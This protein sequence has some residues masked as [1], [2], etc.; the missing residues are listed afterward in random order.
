[1]ERF[2]ISIK[3]GVRIAL[4]AIWTNKTRAILTTTCIVI[5]IV[6]VT[7]MN[8]VTDGVDR[9]F[10]DSMDMLGR[11]VVYIEKWPWGL[12]GGDYKWWEYRNRR[13]IELDYI[14]S[15]QERSR[16]ASVVS[17]AAYASSTLRY[18][19]RDAT[20][21]GVNGMSPNYYEIGGFDIEYG[22]FFTESEDQRAANVVILGASVVEAIFPDEDPLNKMIRLQGQR[23]LVIGTMVK[24]G[25]F[26]GLEDMDNR[27]LIPIQ[28]YKKIF[29]LR[30]GLRLTVQFPDEELAMEGE[31]EVEGIMRQ[32]RRLDPIQEN[33]FAI[34]KPGMFEEQFQSMKVIIYGIGIFLT[35]LA[36][37]VGGIGVMNIMFVSVKERTREIGIRKAVGA[38]SWEIL[39]QFLIEAIIIC[40]IGGV[41]GVLLSMGVTELINQFFIAYMDWTTVVQAVMICTFIGL[42]FGFLPSWKAAKSDP[43]DSLRYE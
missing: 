22:R 30:N 4:H 33:D 39:M 6:S 3:E 9:S 21:A 18:R 29:G 17:A 11:N 28:T 16:L 38:K 20:N 27:V 37:F 31:Y 43:I 12:G 14:E 7:A 42:L 32:I 25:S 13:E 2:L 10:E 23:F 41:I 1:M 36:L 35:G 8:T 34:N 19:D 24:Q 15:L 40:M 5:G 26:L